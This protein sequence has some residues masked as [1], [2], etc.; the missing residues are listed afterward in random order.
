MAPWPNSCGSSYYL[1]GIIPTAVEDYTGLALPDCGLSISQNPVS[2][3]ALITFNLA[4]PGHVDLTVFDLSG[5]TVSSLASGEFAAGS[6]AVSWD[7]E[8]SPAGVYVVRLVTGAIEETLRAV[9]F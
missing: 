4:Q 2:S 7:V 6:H 3:S 5:R 9:R 8:S 1:G